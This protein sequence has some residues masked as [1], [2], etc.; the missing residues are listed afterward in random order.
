MNM[1]I[2]HYLQVNSPVERVY[3]VISTSRGIANWWAR[4]AKGHAELGAILQLDFGPDYLWQAQVTQMVPL[5]E[6]ELTMIKAD[7]DWMDSTIGFQLSSGENGTNVRFFHRGW[8]EANEH[9]YISCYCWA[10]Y[11]RIMKRFVEH[12]EFVDYA[13]RLNV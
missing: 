4:D 1:D 5:A 8:R 11:L 3:P 9:Y 2:V 13:E 12:G 6:F 7:P 10:M